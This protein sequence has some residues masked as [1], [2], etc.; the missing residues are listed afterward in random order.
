MAPASS[1]SIS[2]LSVS[3]PFLVSLISPSPFSFITRTSPSNHTLLSAFLLSLPQ[4]SISFSLNLSV[5]LSGSELETVEGPP[6]VPGLHRD[7]DP[8]SGSLVQQEEAIV[9]GQREEQ[10]YKPPKEIIEHLALKPQQS[11]SVP[12]TCHHTLL[13]LGVSVHMYIHMSWCYDHTR[14][15]TGL[16][17]CMCLK[18]WTICTLFGQREKC[19]Y[20]IVTYYRFVYKFIGLV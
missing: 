13:H 8:T 6:D 7:E 15:L 19:S 11:S 12:L 14:I 4:F 18:S 2:V 16:H 20:A 1:V 10:S 17:A 9:D 5:L 3:H